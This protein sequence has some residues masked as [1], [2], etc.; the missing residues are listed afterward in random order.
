MIFVSS[1][2]PEIISRLSLQIQRNRLSFHF[3][4]IEFLHNC[5]V[6]TLGLFIIPS[7]I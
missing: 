4:N 3:V 1:I 5:N 7:A 6:H 2:D